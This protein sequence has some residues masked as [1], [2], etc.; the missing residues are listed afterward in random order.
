MLGKSK[1]IIFCATISARYDVIKWKNF[2][3]YWP[4]VRLTGGYT[5]QTASNA[6]FDVFFDVCLNRRLHKQLRACV[7]RRQVGHC[8]VTVM[9]CP[10]EVTD[11]TKYPPLYFVLAPGHYLDQCFSYSLCHVFF[12]VINNMAYGAL[13][14]IHYTEFFKLIRICRWACQ[15]KGVDQDVRLILGGNPDTLDDLLFMFNLR[16]CDQGRKPWEITLNM[17]R[18]LQWE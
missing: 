7:L 12:H 2:S 4:F 18:G 6:E 8:D 16:S 14:T 3:R 13:V 11:S 17:E 10:P 1:A 15:S 9:Y 5:S